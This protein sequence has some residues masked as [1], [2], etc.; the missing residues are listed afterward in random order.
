MCSVVHSCGAY[1]MLCVGGRSAAASRQANVPAAGGV[2]VY[3]R[4]CLCM[5]HSCIVLPLRHTHQ[6]PYVT[7][8]CFRIRDKD[9]FGHT[10]LGQVEMDV[11]VHARGPQFDWYPLERTE[12]M[13]KDVRNQ[14]A[15]AC[16]PCVSRCT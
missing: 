13:Q 12:G 6:D 3:R 15:T 14:P 11:D 7:R 4:Q 16:L 8:L 2:G 5:A 10:E 1:V 9:T